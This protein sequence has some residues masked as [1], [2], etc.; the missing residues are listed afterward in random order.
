MCVGGGGRGIVG[1]GE[2]SDRGTTV[3]ITR[4]CTAQLAP[5]PSPRPPQI[6]AGSL[7][8]LKA[9]V[10]RGT[11]LDIVARRGR[12]E[13]VLQYPPGATEISWQNGQPVQRP[14]RGPCQVCARARPPTD[15]SGAAPANCNASIGNSC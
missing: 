4:I 12:L 3:V 10:M 13:V 1:G 14:Y 15:A 9:P 2:R 7:L 6:T 11:V 5:C 8:P